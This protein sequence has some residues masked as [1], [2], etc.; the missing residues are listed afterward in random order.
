MKL[1]ST[2]SRQLRFSPRRIALLAV[3][4]ALI[5]LTGCVSHP[6][7][8]AAVPATPVNFALAASESTPT[9][10]VPDAAPPT[11]D[12]AQQEPMPIPAPEQFS[13][14]WLAD[15]QSIAY[16]ED[17]DVFQAMGEWIVEQ[18]PQLNVKYIVQTGDMVDNG[19]QPKQWKSFGV[20]LD[21][22]YG[23][24]P[25]LPIAGNHDL[26]VK[27]EDYRIYLERPFVKALPED[28]VYKRGRAV[29][30]EFQAGGQDFLLLGAGWNADVDSTVW[31]NGV[32][33]AHPNHVAILMFH[34]YIRANGELSRPGIALH[35]L[36][37]A[38]NPNV[39]LVLCGHLRGNGYRLEQF[40][41]NADGKP[42]REVNAMLYNYQGYTRVKSGQ[43]RV[44]RFDTAA[45]SIH[46]TTYS[47]YNKQYYRDDF[48]QSP[49]FDLLNAF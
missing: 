13:L 23:K 36:V 8:E 1:Q 38:K 35:D 11:P 6:Q 41:D 7:G 33:R 18:A 39:R 26:G 34:S 4:L 31:M 2:V 28:H 3:A 49:E 29:Y 20:L 47:P 16:H 48:F 42:D 17:I 10:P 30:A 25:Y 9:Q 21:Q 24:I 19:F 32:L 44:L 40:D 14:I 37:V 15:T 5:L 27:L 22:F 43:I 45:R 12:P 46:V